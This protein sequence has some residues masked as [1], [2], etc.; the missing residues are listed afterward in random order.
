MVNISCLTIARLVYFVFNGGFMPNYNLLVPCPSC[1]HIFKGS[2]HKWYGGE[3]LE[4]TGYLALR[5][6]SCGN[7][8]AEDPSSLVLV[9]N[10]L[11]K[12]Y[13]G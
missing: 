9:Q 4:L 10:E 8:F 6:P 3:A 2:G 1:G 12:R 5:C 7:E 11:L 13:Q